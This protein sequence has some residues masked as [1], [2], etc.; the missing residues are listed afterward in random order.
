MVP[1]SLGKLI[2][3]RAFAPILLRLVSDLKSSIVIEDNEGK[4]L[5]ATDGAE[6]LTWY[7]VSVAGEVI[8]RVNGTEKVAAIASLLSSMAE[9]EV[10]K[11]ALVSETLNKY[12]EVTLLYDMV[13]KVSSCLDTKEVARLVIEEARKVI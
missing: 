7:P 3:K 13:E 10:E 1:V 12:K 9:S 4:L 11:R 5:M 6:R 8:G 2:K